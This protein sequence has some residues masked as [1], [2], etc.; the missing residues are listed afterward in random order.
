MIRSS[1]RSVIWHHHLYLKIVS[2][3]SSLI[4]E[5]NPLWRQLIEPSYANQFDEFQNCSLMIPNDQDQ[6]PFGF[7]L[8]QENSLILNIKLRGW[9]KNSETR[10]A[11]KNCI[12]GASDIFRNWLNLPEIEIEVS[13][14]LESF[15]IF[16]GSLC[17]ACFVWKYCL[18]SATTPV[19]HRY[20]TSIIWCSATNLLFVRPILFW[21]RQFHFPNSFFGDTIVEVNQEH[22]HQHLNFFEHQTHFGRDGPFQHDLLQ[23]FYE[24]LL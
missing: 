24:L 10:Y 4:V 11:R 19:L 3:S 21:N 7:E 9:S 18:E 1:Y 17:K 20:Y 16:D 14:D 15:L 13:Y 5:Q 23:L 6:M 8:V 2:W 12:F 22:F